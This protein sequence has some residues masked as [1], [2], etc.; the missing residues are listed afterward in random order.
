MNKERKPKPKKNKPHKTERLPVLR[1]ASSLAR[2]D[3]LSAYLSEVRKYGKLSEEEEKE[4]AIKLR[5]RRRR[6]RA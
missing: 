3:P 2:L 6:R 5:E 1:E 4:L